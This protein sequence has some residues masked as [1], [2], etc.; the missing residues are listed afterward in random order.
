MRKAGR[1]DEHLQK[2]GA[3]CGGTRKDAI[4][5]AAGSERTKNWAEK[6]FDDTSEKK[7]GDEVAT[8]SSIPTALQCMQRSPD[9]E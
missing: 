4:R 2:R 1:L 5:I 9:Q 3:L 7:G 6:M 8:K